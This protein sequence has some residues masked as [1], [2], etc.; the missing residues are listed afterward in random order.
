MTKISIKDYSM[1]D[2]LYLAHESVFVQGEEMSFE[3]LEIRVSFN[4]EIS[5]IPTDKSIFHRFEGC[6]FPSYACIF[7]DLVVCF[8]LTHFEKEVLNHRI[9]HSQIHYCATGFVQAFKYWY[10]YQEKG[11]LAYQGIFFNFFDVC[12]ASKGVFSHRLVSLRRVQ[13]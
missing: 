6:F 12:P 1:V 5:P 9:P 11:S 4:S 2:S 7:Q 8:P 10:E 13:N 3:H